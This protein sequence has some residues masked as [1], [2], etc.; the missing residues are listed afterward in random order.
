MIYDSQKSNLTQ[1]GRLARRR[2]SSV[3]AAFGVHA[4]VARIRH[5]ADKLH[6][7]SPLGNL[8]KANLLLIIITHMIQNTTQG[9]PLHRFAA[10]T[11]LVVGDISQNSNGTYPLA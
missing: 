2:A 11:L 5:Y 4:G 6:P 9:L 10:A 1:E 3:L 8:G 7:S